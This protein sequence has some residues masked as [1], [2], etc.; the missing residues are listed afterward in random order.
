MDVVSFFL[1]GE[2]F[3][4]P[5]PLSSAEISSDV[6]VGIVVKFLEGVDVGSL[7]DNSAG[8]GVELEQHGLERIELG[9]VDSDDCAV[10]LVNE[11][12]HL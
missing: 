3:F 11:H 12:L 10:K 7:A 9:W 4:F 6:D 1:A 2:H 8:V 5:L